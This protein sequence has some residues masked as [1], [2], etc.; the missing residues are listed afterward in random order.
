MIKIDFYLGVSINIM[1]HTIPM[2]EQQMMFP[3]PF[4][5]LHEVFMSVKCVIY[6]YS[7]LY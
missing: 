7:I 5:I 2:S 3:M 1:I 4:V 6:G